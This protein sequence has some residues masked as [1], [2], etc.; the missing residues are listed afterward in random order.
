MLA[1]Q[2]KD[3]T[4]IEEWKRWGRDIHPFN[5][6]GYRRRFRER[7][8]KVMVLTKMEKITDAGV[9]ITT[10]G[11]EQ[12]L[13][14]DT[15]VIAVGVEANKRLLEELGT[16]ADVERIH[17]VGDCVAPRKVFNAIHD[18]LRTAVNI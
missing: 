9:V 15:V 13:N 16:M 4:V 8:I 2:G 1:T 14:A 5:I 17:S 3:V 10:E 12:T 6:M 18:G 11:E 7:G